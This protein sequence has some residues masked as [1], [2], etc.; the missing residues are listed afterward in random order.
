MGVLISWAISILIFVLFSSFPFHIL[1]D[2]PRGIHFV[3]VYHKDIGVWDYKII[4]RKNTAKEQILIFLKEALFG[5]IFV[6]LC[7]SLAAVFLYIKI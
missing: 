7:C 5:C 6:T 3:D 1:W 4:I 2:N